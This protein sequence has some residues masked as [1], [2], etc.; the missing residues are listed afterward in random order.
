MTIKIR[1]TT[2]CCQEW[3]MVVWFDHIT[4]HSH[5]NYTDATLS[6]SWI[7]ADIN[8]KKN[9][10]ALA[11]KNGLTI[12]YLL[13]NELQHTCH[14]NGT[15]CVSNPSYRTPMKSAHVPRTSVAIDATGAPRDFGLSSPPN[16]I[17]ASAIVSQCVCFVLWVFCLSVRAKTKG[18]T[19]P[20]HN[21]IIC[22][23]VCVRYTNIEPTQCEPS[24]FRHG[25]KIP[26]RRVVVRAT[27]QHRAARWWLRANWWQLILVIVRRHLVSLSSP[28]ST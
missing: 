8:W 27:K 16:K 19:Q 4:F 6:C 26:F 25:H 24:K 12:L 9:Y 2:I 17:S 20:Q 28:S 23:C 10:H 14:Q 5:A 3:S 1:S 13:C 11:S 22:I 18:C 15:K 7:Y 21:A